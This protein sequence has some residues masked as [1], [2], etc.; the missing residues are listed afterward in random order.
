[1]TRATHR[2]HLGLLLAA[3]LLAAPAVGELI[4]PVLGPAGGAA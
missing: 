1:M 2:A 4:V 3:L